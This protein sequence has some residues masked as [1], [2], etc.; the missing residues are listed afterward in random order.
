MAQKMGKIVSKNN[1]E[2]RGAKVVKTPCPKCGKPMEVVKL[3]GA[4]KGMFR[5]CP[6]CG[7]LVP[8]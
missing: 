8:V 6:A 1:P 4:T 3:V 7:E 2:A 5:S